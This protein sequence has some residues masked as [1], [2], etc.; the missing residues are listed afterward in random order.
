MASPLIG[1]AGVNSLLFASN[2]YARKLV[3]PFPDLT[4][5]QI[6][7]AGS[8]AGAVQAVLA[9]PVEMFKASP[10]ALHSPPSRT[11]TVLPFSGA[12]ASEPVD[13]AEATQGRRWGDVPKIRLEARYHAGILGEASSLCQRVVMAQ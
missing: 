11:V 9:S 13:H 7:L 8:M 3:S 4:I 1:I 5:P 10:L 6:M 2:N 12:N